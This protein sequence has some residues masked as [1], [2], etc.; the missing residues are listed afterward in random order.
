MQFIILASGRGKR[1][2]SITSKKPKSFIKIK[3]TKLIDIIL[4]S[5][6]LF[7]ET[8]IVTGYKSKLFQKNFYD[9]KLVKNKNYQNT[10]MVESMFLASKFINSDLIVSY[11]DILYDKDI[12]KELI[13]KNKSC[14]PLNAKWKQNWLSRMSYKKMLS[15]A[16]NIKLTKSQIVEIGTKI[17]S[18]NLP[19]YQYMGIIKFQ[20]KD[21]FSLK[22]FYKSLNNKKID[23]TTF[24]D[25]S[26]KKKI[27][28][29]SYFITSKYWLEIDS[30]NDLNFARKK[31]KNI[32][33]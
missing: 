9:I 11:S 14:M 10:N 2:K 8:I 22:K 16:E 28:K 4:K 23:M 3:N 5:S 13:T 24:L 27:I 20:R 17:N 30:K 31:I 18:N 12:L 15:D 1:L 29:M 21:F 19:K 33:L 7:K 26:I 25:L 32:S 6:N